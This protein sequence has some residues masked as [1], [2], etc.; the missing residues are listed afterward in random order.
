MSILPFFYRIR[1]ICRVRNKF[2][3]VFFCENRDRNGISGISSFYLQK[4]EPLLVSYTVFHYQKCAQ[5]VRLL[6]IYVVFKKEKFRPTVNLEV[7]ER[8]S[9]H[10][11]LMK[12]KIVRVIQKSLANGLKKQTAKI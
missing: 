11:I 3:L 12:I 7:R 9:S 5:N 1:D 6:L 8:A 4:F 10:T 2:V